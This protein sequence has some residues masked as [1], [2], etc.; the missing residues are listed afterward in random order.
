[1]KPV[2]MGFLQQLL[3]YTY[4]LIKTDFRGNIYIVWFQMKDLH[5]MIS[6]EGLTLYDSDEEFTLY[7]FRWRIYIVWFQMKDLHCMISDE[8]FTLYDFRWRI[9]ILKKIWMWTLWVA[10]HVLVVSRRKKSSF[11]S[12]WNKSKFNTTVSWTICLVCN[13]NRQYS[14]IGFQMIMIMPFK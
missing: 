14:I 3:P 1:M 5:C 9:Y 7:D 4:F 13:G 10:W 6:D 8:G 11:Q 12:F 2:L